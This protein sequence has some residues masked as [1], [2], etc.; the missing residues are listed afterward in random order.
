M[1]TSPKTPLPPFGPQPDLPGRADLLQLVPREAL[2]LDPEQRARQMAAR[3]GEAPGEI[4]AET[5]EAIGHALRLVA[6]SYRLG[7]FEDLARVARRLRKLGVESGLPDMARAADNVLQTT[8]GED[9]AAIAATVAR[10]KRL[11]FLALDEMARG[12]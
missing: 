10:L 9:A 1:S 2:R 3:A 6:S 11:G 4:A 7:Q 12:L 5:V 8:Q